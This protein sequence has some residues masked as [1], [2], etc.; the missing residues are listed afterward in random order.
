MKTLEVVMT[1]CM[2]YLSFKYLLHHR[3]HHQLHQ[4]LHHHRGQC[5]CLGHLGRPRNLRQLAGQGRLPKLQIIRHNSVIIWFDSYIF[6]LFTNPLIF[7]RV[8]A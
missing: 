6:L 1:K 5:Q 2:K 7:I 8:M 4:H 3:H